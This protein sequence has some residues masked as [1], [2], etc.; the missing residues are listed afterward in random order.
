M[1]KKAKKPLDYKGI[2]M[3]SKPE[4]DFCHYLEEL[5]QAGFIQ[6]W[7]RAPTYTLT[8]G[9]EIEYIHTQELKTKT[10]ETER[11]QVLLRESVYTPDFKIIWNRKAIGVFVET[12]PSLIVGK[13]PQTRPFLCNVDWTSYIEVKPSSTFDV[14]GMLRV[15]KMNQKFMWKIHSIFVNLI[16]PPDLFCSTFTP[17]GVNIPMDRKEKAPKWPRVTLKEYANG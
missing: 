11:K 6:V 13:K 16:V 1:K 8:K 15:F 10:K 12:I 4:L 9:F 17:Q 2:P 3:D 5:K 14:D 7:E